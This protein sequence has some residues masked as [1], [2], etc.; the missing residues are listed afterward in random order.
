[1]TEPGLP[2]LVLQ[3]GNIFCRFYSANP[4]RF[5]APVIR[6][7]PTLNLVYFRHH[8]NSLI[9]YQQKGPFTTQHTHR[10]RKPYFRLKLPARA[11]T[12]GTTWARLRQKN[13]KI[14]CW[15]RERG[16][17]SITRDGGAVRDRAERRE[18]AVTLGSLSCPGSHS[19]TWHCPAQVPYHPPS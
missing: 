6:S 7:E 12:P 8:F 10:T 16:E 18:T 13:R 9:V 5:L 17:S 11:R 1:M 15:F 14:P 19:G 2:V 4:E 3:V